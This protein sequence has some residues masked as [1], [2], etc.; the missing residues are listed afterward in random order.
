[1]KYILTFVLLVGCSTMPVIIPDLSRPSVMEDSIK[2][3][4]SLGFQSSYLWILWYVPIVLVIGAWGYR[5]F[6]K[7]VKS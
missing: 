7:G 4:E 1:M 6:I 5:K 3:A 2:H